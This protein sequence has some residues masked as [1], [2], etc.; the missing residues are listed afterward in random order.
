MLRYNN[1]AITEHYPW[2]QGA[3]GLVVNS[4]LIVQSALIVTKE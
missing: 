2:L 1:N 3:Y 4:Q